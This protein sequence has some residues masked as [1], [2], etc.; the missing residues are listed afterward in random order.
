MSRAFNDYLSV[1]CFLLL[2]AEWRS[3]CSDGSLLM[4][5]TEGKTGPPAGS[6]SDRVRVSF[7]NLH[8]QHRRQSACLD[9]L[10]APIPDRY[11]HDWQFQ[12]VA[13]WGYCAEFFQSWASCLY[14]VVIMKHVCDFHQRGGLM[15]LHRNHD[16][17]LPGICRS[18]KTPVCEPNLFPSNIIL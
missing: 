1:I 11:V 18:I 15:V 5:R 6:V 14:M 12:L 13:H 17:W 10:F 4:R 9:V 8:H 16:V 3:G 7:Q 2:L